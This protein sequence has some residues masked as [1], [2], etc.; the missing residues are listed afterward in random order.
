MGVFFKGGLA[1][2]RA[3]KIWL[4]LSMGLF[5]AVCSS[6]SC[7]VVNDG[8]KL[9]VDIQPSTT[10]LS[11]SWSGFEDGKERN[12]ILR[13]EWAV[14]SS[15]YASG[16]EAGTCREN[17]GFLGHPNVV[18]WTNVEKATSASANVKLADGETYFVVI[19]ATT[20]FGYQRY[21]NSDGVTIDSSFV[22]QQE[23]VRE[24]RAAPAATRNHE[25]PANTRSC[26]QTDECAIDQERRCRAGQVSVREYLEEFYGP[27]QFL[28]ENSAIVAFRGAVVAP[29]FVVAGE[30]DLRTGEVIGIAIGICA[31]F[32]F[33]AL[34]LIFLTSLGSSGSKFDTNV[35][36]HENVEEF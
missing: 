28:A 25:Q 18:G 33:L 11:A 14:V 20:A 24:K 34:I 30:D 5:V 19:R 31:F 9:D 10:K 16:L 15:S 17:A 36:R 2:L 32:C 6:L 21:A 26:S 35:R 3:M 7:G 29:A 4:L 22:E 12:R 13:Y 27:A 1:G 8:L 23:E